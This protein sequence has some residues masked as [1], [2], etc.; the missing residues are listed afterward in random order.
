MANINKIESLLKAAGI[1]RT[2]LCS[3][4]GQGAWYLNNVKHGKAQISDDSLKIIAKV[5]H[6]TPEYLRDETDDPSPAN[7][8][9]SPSLIKYIGN[10]GI[11]IP[12]IGAS[13]AGQPIEAIQEYIDDSDPDTWEEISETLANT[14]DMVAVRIHGD[15]M[16]PDIKNGDIVI[17]RMQN[18]AESGD[19][20]LVLVNG[21]EV[22]CKK[23]K[24]R[25]DGVMLISNNLDYEPMFFS[26][27]EIELLPVR[28]YGVVVELRRRM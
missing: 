26:N 21:N 13:A 10:K 19:I 22:T 7:K 5:L 16:E 17:V 24:K 20:A 2:F 11:R 25:P 1:T 14:G 27:K 4:M 15:S 9:R 3:Q 23:I 28:I 8:D 6:T 12:V 18:N